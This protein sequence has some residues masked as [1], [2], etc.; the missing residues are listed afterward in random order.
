MKLFRFLSILLFTVAFG[1]LLANGHPAKTQ[2]KP[3]ESVNPKIQGPVKS[4]APVAPKVVVVGNVAVLTNTSSALAPIT[5]AVQAAAIVGTTVASTILIIARDAASAYSGYSGLAGYGIPYQ[6]LLVPQTGAAL[7]TLSSSA[8][9]GNFG[10][11]V[12]LSEVSYD[13]GATGF[14]S[15]LTAA[16]W[17][18]LFTYQ[19]NFGG[20]GVEQLVSISNSAAF[21]TAGLKT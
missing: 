21:P 6:L 18:T 7:P 1:A 13:Y 9:A 11:I 16:Q 14:Q 12:V 20:A 2:P 8:T 5:P 19:L 15:A 3:T 17:T 4:P 10:A